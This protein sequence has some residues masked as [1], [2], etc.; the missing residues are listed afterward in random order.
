MYQVQFEIM[1]TDLDTSTEY[2]TITMNGANFGQCGPFS[3]S[4]EHCI[5]DDCSNSL[6]T[7]NIQSDSSGQ[8]RIVVRYSGQVDATGHG[9]ECTYQG[10]TVTGLVRI[11]LTA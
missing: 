10:A 8:I 2:A 5:Y 1:I 3:S 7:T 4:I 9:V 6:T 11:T